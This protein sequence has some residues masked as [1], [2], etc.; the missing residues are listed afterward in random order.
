MEAALRTVVKV[1]GPPGGGNSTV[2]LKKLE[3]TEVRGMEGIR[4]ASVTLPPNPTGV[5]R[6]TKEL[7]LRV[8]VA[9]G[10][11]EGWREAVWPCL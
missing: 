5:L 6:N 7:V 1:A 4:E 2:G 8:A 3:F 10:E 11:K 9:N